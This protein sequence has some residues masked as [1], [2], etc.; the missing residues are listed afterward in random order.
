MIP[1]V[2]LTQ[3]TTNTQENHKPDPLAPEPPKNFRERGQAIIEAKRFLTQQGILFN[4][5]IT[6]YAA[7]RYYLLNVPDELEERWESI[8]VLLDQGLDLDAKRFRGAYYAHPAEIEP[9]LA[10]GADAALCCTRTNLFRLPQKAD[11]G[12]AL[13]ALSRGD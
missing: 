1:R 6:R 5:F 7:I 12:V 4:A 11:P 13:E 9:L 8:Q 3:D 10:S 2:T